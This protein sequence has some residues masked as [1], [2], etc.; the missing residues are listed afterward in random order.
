MNT[1]KETKEELIKKV[2]DPSWDVFGLRKE[3][4]K[5]KIREPNPISIEDYEEILKQGKNLD[6][7]KK[8]ERIAFFIK[9]MKFSYDLEFSKIKTKKR[10]EEIQ[11]IIR[12]YEKEKY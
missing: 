11:K 4:K 5:G 1:K 6:S 7:L 9:L 10:K 2:N 3:I 12:K 8:K